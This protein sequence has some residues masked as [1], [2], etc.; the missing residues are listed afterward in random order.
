[1]P[2]LFGFLSRPETYSVELPDDVDP[3]FTQAS[4]AGLTPTEALA[5]QAAPAHSVD[6]AAF[7]FEYSFP[8]DASGTRIDVYESRDSADVV[9][10]VW[11]LGSSCM[12]MQLRVRPEAS[13]SD[14]LATFAIG[15]EAQVDGF[16]IPRVFR[17]H[18][19]VAG[20]PSTNEL[21]RDHV[22]FH[23]RDSSRMVV[24]RDDGALGTDGSF[25]DGD[26]AWTAATT[27]LG[28]TVELDGPRE[29]KAQLAEQARA[30][31]ESLRE[32]PAAAPS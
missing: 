22:L 21:H 27:A 7:G 9:M 16:G 3:E 26:F 19:L 18:G 2:T 17:R 25:V 28:I 5:I 23:V 31:A 4:A 13:K 10:A 29:Q 24:L 20:N 30:V 32:V 1:M 8:I 11:N 12:W 6:V 14:L 15:L